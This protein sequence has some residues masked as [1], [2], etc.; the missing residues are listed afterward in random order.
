MFNPLYYLWYLTA[1]CE[2]PICQGPP[3]HYSGHGLTQYAT[4]L[5]EDHTFAKIC[6]AGFPLFSKIS[7]I[8][9]EGRE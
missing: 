7:M 1:D 5:S 4:T 2:I 3:I 6:W 8:T 9:W